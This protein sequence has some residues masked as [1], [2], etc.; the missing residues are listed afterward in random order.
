MLSFVSALG[1]TA[2][3]AVALSGMRWHP[4]WKTIWP[5]AVTACTKKGSF[6]AEVF[7]QWVAE[8]LVHYI[9][10]TR[11]IVGQGGSILVLV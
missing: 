4:D 5:E 2:P 8:T 7:A 9:L 1:E 11:G 3:L 6:A 10:V